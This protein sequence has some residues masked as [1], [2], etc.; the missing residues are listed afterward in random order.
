MD[1]DGRGQL[2]AG[3]V[4]EIAIGIEAAG[5][6]KELVEGDRAPPIRAPLGQRVAGLLVQGEK[7]FL[8]GD[9]GGHGGEAIH[10]VVP[11]VRC[12]RGALE[13]AAAAE[14][15]GR[16]AYLG[17]QRSEQRP[18]HEGAQGFPRAAQTLQGA[19]ADERAEGRE[20][21]PDQQACQRFDAAVPIGVVLVG[22]YGRQGEPQQDE[23]GSEHVRPRLDAVGY[24]CRGMPG[25]AGDDF[26][27]RK[28]AAHQHS[29]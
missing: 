8:H 4:N 9:Q 19:V 22:R 12:K 10:Q 27:D 5:V 24:H 7:A 18:D 20:S 26:D 29:G 1:A 13:P 28:R 23:P 17:D 15:G 11:R 16:K 3:R 14:L 25:Q 6:G 2:I 21:E